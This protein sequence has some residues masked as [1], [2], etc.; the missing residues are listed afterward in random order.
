MDREMNT[1][2]GGGPNDDPDRDPNDPIGDS[3]Y[4]GGGGVL[5][6]T[7]DMEDPPPT[8]GIPGAPTDERVED[9]PRD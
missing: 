5:P 7:G 8:T 1:R 4:M 3:A 6:P 9:E 2:P